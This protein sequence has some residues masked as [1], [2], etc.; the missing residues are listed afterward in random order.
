LYMTFDGGS[1]NAG[2]SRR[3]VLNSPQHA[4]SLMNDTVFVE[5]SPALA[6]EYA[7]LTTDREARIAALFHH[8][9]GRS[10]TPEE[11]ALLSEFFTQQQTR[12]ESQSL[13]PAALTGGDKNPA[14]AAWTTLARTLL[15]L[16]EVMTKE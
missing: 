12:F 10:C 16:D 11:V 2:I 14:I 4:L 8:I 3:E 6:R 9:T 13:D 15:N 7:A 5:A 1:G